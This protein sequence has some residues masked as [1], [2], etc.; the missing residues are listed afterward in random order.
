MY[1]KFAVTAK[2]LNMYDNIPALTLCNIC[3]IKR[4]IKIK[5]IMKN[6]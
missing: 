4:H 6:R 3:Y 1:I 2:N 5:P